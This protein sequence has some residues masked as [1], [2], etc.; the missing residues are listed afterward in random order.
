[1]G[2]STLAA[3]R[4]RKCERDHVVNPKHKM[5]ESEPQV[6]RLSDPI[7]GDVLP[8]ASSASQGSTPFPVG[9]DLFKSDFTKDS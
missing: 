3:G 2:E 5:K 9:L 8:P 4:N 1:M 6:G 7:S